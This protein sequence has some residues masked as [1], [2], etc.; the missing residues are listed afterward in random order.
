MKNK[1]KKYRIEWMHNCNWR[2]DDIPGYT[3]ETVDEAAEEIRTQFVGMQ[4]RIVEVK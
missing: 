3:F 2:M 4:T 1:T